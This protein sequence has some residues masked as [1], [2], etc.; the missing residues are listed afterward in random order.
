[1][2]STVGNSALN[3]PFAYSGRE[4]D[5]EIGL[6][7]YRNRFYSPQVGRFISEDPLGLRVGLNTYQYAANSPENFGD[8]FGLIVYTAHVSGAGWGGAK[9]VY[10]NNTKCS[11][12]ACKCDQDQ[13]VMQGSLDLQMVG[14]VTINNTFTYDK[15]GKT[16]T[17]GRSP[18]RIRATMEHELKHL[19][20]RKAKIEELNKGVGG[21]FGSMAEC[22]RARAGIEA[23]WQGWSNRETVHANVES[24]QATHSDEGTG[25]EASSAEA[26]GLCH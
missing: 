22:E 13:F 21:S 17:C 23:D 4:W 6:Y 20:N 5:H 9:Y 26:L 12:K 24:P 14:D 1:L 25:E 16:R 19:E 18:D 3:S 10:N 7:Y 8:P 15:D 2:F 11:K